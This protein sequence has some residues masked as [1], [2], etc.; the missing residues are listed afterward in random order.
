MKDHVHRTQRRPLAGWGLFALV[1]VLLCFGALNVAVR[2]TSHKLEDGVL[3]ELRPEGVTAVDVAARGGAMAAGIRPG[4]VLVAIDGAPVEKVEQVQAAL[5]GATRSTTALLCRTSPGRAAHAERRGGTGA[6]RQ[7]DAVCRRR[8]DRHLHLLV[9]ASVRLRRPH[10]P[11]TLHFFWLC[12]AFFGTLTFSFSR[13]D[14]LDWYFYWSDAVATVLLGPLFLHFTLVFPDRPASWVRGPGRRFVALLYAPALLLLSLNIIAVG[15]L[16]LNTSLYSRV[17]VT[18][19]QIEPLYLSLFMVGGLA[20]LIRA[21]D[22]VRS[23]TARRQLRWIVWGTAFG[24]GPFAIGYA[25]PY[26]LGLRVS[27]PM[28]LSL[29]PLSLVPLA[30]RPP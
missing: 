2:A 12:M 8:R 7:P 4:D 9:G 6:C 26:A 21:M 25:L 3:W 5:L 19:D 28:E 13:L 18:L 14:R 10:D 24:A 16:P 23:A 29:I 11:A 30:S 17:L 22:R 27:L 20:I 1:G 15:R